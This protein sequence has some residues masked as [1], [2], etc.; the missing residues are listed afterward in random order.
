MV[1]GV[2]DAPPPARRRHLAGPIAK[3]V[4]TAVHAHSGD[5]DALGVA[6]VVAVRTRWVDRNHD[7][8]QIRHLRIVNVATH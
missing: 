3:D 5:H 4:P 8:L 1:E 7:A 6:F 2:Y